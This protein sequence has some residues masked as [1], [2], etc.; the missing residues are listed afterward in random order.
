MECICHHI[1]RIYEVF[2]EHKRV[3]RQNLI[4]IFYISPP[5]ST[6]DFKIIILS[7]QIIRFD[8]MNKVYGNQIINLIIFY[9]SAHI[10]K[11]TYVILNTPLFENLLKYSAQLIAS[12]DKSIPILLLA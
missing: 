10:T 3:I 6:Y 12:G 9:K 5:I 8:I 4:S 1:I 11:R 2:H 7:S